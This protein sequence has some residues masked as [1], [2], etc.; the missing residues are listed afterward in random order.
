MNHGDIDANFFQHQPFLDHAKQQTDLKIKAF[1]KGA[2]THVGL[3]FQKYQRFDDLP[4]GASVAI[5]NG[6][7][8]QGR[9]LL[10]LQQPKLIE[11]KQVDHYLSNLTDIISSPKNLKFIEVKDPKIASAID[12]VDLAFG[13]PHYLRMAKTTD[14]EQALL[15]DDHTSDRFAILFAMQE[16]YQD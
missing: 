4:Q 1:A 16:D 3:Y 8:N 12:Y 10:L 9:A 7:V 5:T 14:P 11:L 2:A 6:P 13:Y 15:F